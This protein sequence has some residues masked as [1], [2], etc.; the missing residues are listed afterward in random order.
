MRTFKDDARILAW[1]VWNEPDNHSMGNYPTAELP[2]KARLVNGLLPQV[3]AWARS[4]GPSQPLTSGLWTSWHK[5]WHPDS[6]QNADLT[7]RI[8]LEQSDIV[9][10][11]HYGG[12]QDFEKS[13]RDLKA[14][15]RPLICTEYL[16]RGNGSTLEAIVPIGKKLNI[17]LI[18]WGFADGKEQTKF[19]WDSWSKRYTADPP[20][21][22]HVLFRADLSPYKPEE[23]ELLKKTNGMK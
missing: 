1:D 14:Y 23:I 7:S 11:H 8:Q 4:Q 17:G 18:N 19:P 9:T 3:F 12:P 13:A 6:L 5:C 10:F 21:W 16:A 2:N 15:G 22:H 20:V